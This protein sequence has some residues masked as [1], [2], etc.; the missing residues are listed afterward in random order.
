MTSEQLTENTS[1]RAA[2]TNPTAE[3]DAGAR[4]D[5]DGMASADA[6]ATIRLPDAAGPLFEQLLQLA[7]RGGERDADSL[8]QFQKSVES[9]RAFPGVRGAFRAKVASAGGWAALLFSSWRHEKYNRQ[10]ASGA[11][12]VREFIRG[13]LQAARQIHP[14]AA[15]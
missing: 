7:M 8:T 13:D 2:G 9:L 10:D 1:S 14:V 15:K 6:A 3:A 11:E 5:D 12:R 4:A